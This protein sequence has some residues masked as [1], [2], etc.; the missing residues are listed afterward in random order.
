MGLFLNSPHPV[1]AASEQRAIV[2]LVAAAFTAT[3]IGALGTD[4]GSCYGQP[5]MAPARLSM[6]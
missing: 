5:P 1:C 6:Q 2:S 3:W 4:W